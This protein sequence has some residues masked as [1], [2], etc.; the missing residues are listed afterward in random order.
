MT[1]SRRRFVAVAGIG[2]LASAVAHAALKPTPAETSGPFK[3]KQ[4]PTE[5]DADLTRVAG[6]SGHAKGVV[7]IVSGRVLRA[8]GTPAAG[9]LVQAWQAN[10]AGRYDH[11][12]DQSPAPLDPDFQGMAELRT[13]A[14]GRF[15]LR[16][17]KPGAYAMSPGNMRTRHPDVFPGR[18]LERIRCIDREHVRARDRSGA[19]GLPQHRV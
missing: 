18:S 11:P 5:H 16:T 6:R 10:A 13:D 8:D 3:P 15:R 12:A 17:I 2:A 7:I 4:L 1:V 19:D 14:E 9:A